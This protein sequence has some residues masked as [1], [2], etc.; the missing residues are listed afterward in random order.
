MSYVKERL[1]AGQTNER[2]TSG[3]LVYNIRRDRS[4]LALID[5]YHFG[6]CADSLIPRP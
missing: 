3:F 5:G 6:E 2:Q 1:P 4:N